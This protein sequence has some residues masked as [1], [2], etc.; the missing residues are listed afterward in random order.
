MSFAL[1]IDDNR[2]TANALADMIRMLGIEARAVLN[3]AA[4]MGLMANEVP[5]VVFLDLNMPGVDGFEVLSYI[6][7]DPR[8]T[9]V[10]VIVITSDDQPE[11]AQ[12]VLQNGGEVVLVKPIVPEQLERALQKV[13]L[14]R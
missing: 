1:V 4:A 8:L 2:Q 11:T 5:Q 10:P 14:P 3:P 12:R 6:K 7:R 9:R 13:G